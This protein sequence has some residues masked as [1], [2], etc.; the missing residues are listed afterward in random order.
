MKKKMLVVLLFA[1]LCFAAWAC[2]GDGE[3]AQEADSH[4]VAVQDGAGE[5]DG[6]QPPGDVPVADVPEEE[7]PTGEDFVPDKGKDVIQPAKCDPACEYLDGM[8]CDEAASE[9]KA[10]ACTSCF[11]DKDCPEGQEC[12][13]VVFAGGSAANVCAGACASHL[14]CPAG[15]DCKE[16]VCKPTALCPP[17][18]GEGKQGEPCTYKDKFHKDCGACQDGLVCIGQVLNESCQFDQ[19]CVFAGLPVETN[20]DCV[21]GVCGTGFCRGECNEDL[22]CDEGFTPAPSGLKCFCYPAEPTGTS[23]AGDPCPIFNVHFEGEYCDAD[24]TCLG[25][26]AD[27]EGEGAYPC[28][29]ADDCPKAYPN[30]DCVAG[31]CGWS[32]CT[33]ECPENEECDAGFYPVELSDGQC[34]CIPKVVGDSKAGEPCPFDVVNPQSEPCLVELTCLGI[35]ASEDSLPCEQDGDCAP[36]SY[37]GP[38]CIEG[39]CGGSF[40]SPDCDADGLC[41]EGFEAIDVDEK[42][43]CV[44]SP[45]GSGKA[46][47][48]CPLGNV[49][50][51]ADFCGEDLSCGGVGAGPMSHVCD[52]PEDCP[53]SY[54]GDAVCFLGHCGSSACASECDENGACPAGFIPYLFGGPFCYCVGPGETAGTALLGD[55]C[56]FFNVNVDAVVCAKG[57]ACFGISANDFSEE[58][59]CK[60]A[61]D[62]DFDTFPGN[63]ACFEGFCGTSFCSAACDV[64]GDCDP[65]YVPLEDEE[66]GACFCVPVQTGSSAVGDACPFGTVN[67]DA[68]FCL[69]GL[70]CLGIPA[71]ES[72]AQCNEDKDCASDPYLGHARC[73]DGQCGTSVCSPACDEDGLCV[74][75]YEPL[76]VGEKCYCVPSYAGQ[77]KAG[78]ACPYYNVNVKS[79]FCLPDLTCAGVPAMS[80]TDECVFAVDCPKV[81]PG[82]AACFNGH[83]GSS[84]CAAQCAEGASCG[85]GE[86]PHLF[87]GHGC[88]CLKSAAVGAGAA[89]DAC[90]FLM[91]NDKSPAC[92]SG[93]A[94]L[95]ILPMPGEAACAAPDEC[96]PEDYPGEAA[97]VGGVCATSF[98]VA[99]C[100]AEGLCAEGFEPLES[101]TDCFCV[102]A[103][104]PA[105]D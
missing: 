79:D 80:T 16:N 49:N 50:P 54:L 75:G 21:G 84:L 58:F 42:C 70:A 97:C 5:I 44:P 18:C 65:G 27:P 38:N 66:T 37:P 48:P 51:S 100:D 103:T 56:P 62:C 55:A 67:D 68:D 98:C 90:P 78:D 82:K 29:T 61:D 45:T 94:C 43:Y 60:T 83:C 64:N 6:F 53:D 77:A 59:A 2:G 15:W 41:A 14:D 20:P 69:A 24:L 76:D 30:A 8:Y 4:D 3:K 88:V 19:D 99:P 31:F 71:D 96:L 28:G 73:V 91:L 34:F 105:E 39:L 9:C 35:A 104:E 101:Q 81:L 40:C 46:G 72:S 36:S 86:L 93:L 57:L 89:G 52:K 74:V 1:G 102:P 7:L 85:V 10:I 87:P 33:P 12:V 26:A 32:F 17:A 13:G 47:D 22:T 63:A 23:E 92:G 11:R 25:I 95:G